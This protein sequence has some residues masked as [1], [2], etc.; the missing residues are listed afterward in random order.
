MIRILILLFI[1]LNVKSQVPYG[2]NSF[3]SAKATFYLDFDGHTVSTAYWNGGNTFY[4]KPSKLTTAQIDSAFKMVAED[5]RPFNVNVTTDSS[6]YFAAPLLRRQRV[7]ITDT[8]EWYAGVGGVA[9]FGSFLWGLEVPCFV[10]SD[11]LKTGRNSGEA[12]SHEIGHTLNLNHQSQCNSSGVFV[13]EYFA[14]VG[15]GEISWSPI[16]G[17]SYSR[18][19]TLWHNGPN[20]FGCT[21]LQDDLSII[22]SS[23]NGFGYRPDGVGNTIEQSTPV[24]ININTLSFSE[25][26]NRTSD[27]DFYRINLT[28]RGKLV[29]TANP[30]NLGGNRVRSNIDIEMS[31]YNG[32]ILLQKYNP[33]TRLNAVI[34][35]TLNAGTYHISINNVANSNVSNYGMIGSYSVE[36][37]FTV[38]ETLNLIL[39]NTQT[40]IQR[41]IELINISGNPNTGVYQI[42]LP[43]RNNFTEIRIYSITGT[44]LKSIRNIQK[45][46]TIDISKYSSGIYIVN[47]DNVKSFKIVKQ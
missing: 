14:G 34:D 26:I 12:I 15:T 46:N 27:T 39:P 6:V 44:L 8:S 17:N 30:Y 31:L 38:E 13:N 35:T 7:I 25:L 20:S 47:I 21:N 24:N 23:T 36:G 2:L 41:Q 42:N 4:A 11:V 40:Q 28:K 5:F 32:T 19:L 29:L 10:F 9:Y 43:N 22:T 18:N 16:M 45:I 37:T 1:A 3:P 33:L